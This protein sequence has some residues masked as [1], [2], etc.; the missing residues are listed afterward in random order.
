MDLF[1]FLVEFSLSIAS[2]SAQ[3]LFS[4]N[5][6]QWPLVIGTG[7]INIAS[8]SLFFSLSVEAGEGSSSRVSCD[9][10]PKIIDSR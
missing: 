7:V 5:S 4:W 9:N 2:N 3:S 8:S 10:S 1:H 6:L